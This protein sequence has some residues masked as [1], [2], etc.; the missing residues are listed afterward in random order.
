MC[1]DVLIVG[2]APDK[3]SCSVNRPFV[4]LSGEELQRGIQI[5]GYRRAD[6]SITSVLLCRPPGNELAK[7]TYA[8]RAENNRRKKLNRGLGEDEEKYVLLPHP[9]ECCRPRLFREVAKFSKVIV[10]GDTAYKTVTSSNENVTHMRGSPHEGWFHGTDGFVECDTSSEESRRASELMRPERST[11]IRIVPTFHPAYVLRQRMWTHVFRADLG[12]A[13]RWFSGRLGWTDPEYITRPSPA[14]LRRFLARPER[15]FAYDLETDAKEPLVAKIRLFGVGTRDKVMVVP[16]LSTDGHTLFYT[17]ADLKEIKDIFREWLTS[18]RSA[19]FSWNGITYD[20]PVIL[21]QLGCGISRHIDGILMHHDVES[22]LPH[23]LGFVGTELT[24]VPAWKQKSEDPLNC[25]DPTLQYRNS[26]DVAVTAALLEPL[27]RELALRDQTAVCKKDHKIQQICAGM[28]RVGMLIDPVARNEHDKRLLAQIV[29]YR[30]I[31]RDVVGDDKF[32][33]NSPPQIAELLFGTWG[34]P[35]V[36]LSEK[37]GAPSTGDDALRTYRVEYNLTDDQRRFIEALRKVRLAV[38]LRGTNIVKFRRR[39]EKL[40]YDPW[41]E[42]SEETE[43][44]R[45]YRKKKD[46]EKY[47]ILLDDGR[48]HSSFTTHV[49]VTGRLASNSP[50]LQNVKINLRNMFVAA[51][52][53][54][55][56]GA[57]ADQLE[58]RYAA[59]RW[60]MQK[61]LEILRDGRD[62]H[63]ETALA[64]FGHAAEEQYALAVEWAK[65]AKKPDGKK[66]KPKEFPAYGRVRDFSKRLRYAVQYGAEDK[67]VHRVISS[68]EDDHG[69]LIYADVSLTDTSTRRR[70]L[71]DADP[72]Y[73]QGWAEEV[74][75]WRKNGYLRERI[76]GRRRDFLN[77]EEFNEIVNFE[78]QSG[79]AALINEATFDLVDAIPFEKWGPGTGLIN[80]CH[81]AL[82]IECPESEGKRVAQIMTECMTRTYPGLDVQFKAEAKIGKTWLDVK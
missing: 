42:D 64:C 69:N 71:L 18:R 41:A 34:L 35:P 15:F 57:D 56:V 30:K 28:H 79:C 50:N 20:A 24:D 43:A 21:Q 61:M 48:V 70:R 63:H 54:V 5:H 27:E 25:D 74:A 6:F 7:L 47:G 60:R 53:N 44:E 13:M 29:K 17:E 31:C 76:W 2:E 11:S 67:T 72:E 80:Q 4:G 1:G 37:T 51:P 8:W 75:L 78:I 77:G 73:E 3:D 14:A 26:R 58:L 55:L 9:I 33:P 23:K 45:T 19:K 59:G 81:D 66:C 65:T 49:P 40:P 62:P 39:T 68:T 36:E 82:C 12:R 32:N 22:E 10:L 52:G 38:K 46:V 16:F